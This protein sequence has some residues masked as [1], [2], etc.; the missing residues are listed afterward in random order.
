M[1]CLENIVSRFHGMTFDQLKPV[2]TELGVPHGTLWRVVR[3]RTKNPRYVTVKKMQ[4]FRP[5][6]RRASK[7]AAE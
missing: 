4:A 6:K 7:A 1:D 2:A 3:G 5:K